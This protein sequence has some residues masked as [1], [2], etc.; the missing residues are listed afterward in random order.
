[1]FSHIMIGA[2]D[3]A[4]SKKFYDAILGVLGH[5]EGVPD[6]KGRYF[7]LAGGNIFAITAPL[8][9]GAATNANG[10]TIGFAAANPEAVDAWHAAGLANGG[11]QCEDP[12]GLR[13]N[14]MY[15]AYLR[16]PSGNKL[17][18]LYREG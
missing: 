5:K 14:G 17:C 12:P 18:A 6:P 13:A 15:V 9:G 16:D 1:M 8:N 7:Y 10:G 3:V 2:N 4:A 11:S